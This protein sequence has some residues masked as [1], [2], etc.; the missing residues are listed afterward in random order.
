M[1]RSTANYNYRPKTPKGA[2]NSTCLYFLFGLIFEYEASKGIGLTRW[3]AAPMTPTPRW[4]I[5]GSLTTHEIGG[6]VT[7][8][9]LTVVLL[10]LLLR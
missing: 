5:M 8:G 7:L 9:L 4:A 2:A 3:L 1:R 6:F 10:V